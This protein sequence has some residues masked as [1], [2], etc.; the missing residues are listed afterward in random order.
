MCPYTFDVNDM[1]KETN[2]DWALFGPEIPGSGG[3]STADSSAQGDATDSTATGE[4]GGKK[5]VVPKPVWQRINKPAFYGAVGSAVTA[6]VIY[7][8]AYSGKSQYD[9]LEN[10]NIKTISDLADLRSSINTKVYISG[11]MGAVALG[12]YVAAFWNIKKIGK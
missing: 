2:D 4:N 3:D 10:P 8:M 1:P 9:D 7:G 12:L 6:A 11:G 5:L